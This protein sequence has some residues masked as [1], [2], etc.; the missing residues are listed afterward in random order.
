MNFLD[1]FILIPTVWFA[2]K[3]FK[4]GL[5]FEVASIIALILG[6]WAAIK[7]SNMVG[8]YFNITG[9]YVDII[10]FVITFAGVIILIFILA[11]A[12]EKAVNITVSETMNKLMGTLFGALKIVFILSILFDFINSMDTREI[13]FK[14][15]VKEASVLY[16][17]VAPVGPFLMP[18]FREAFNTIE[19]IKEPP[20]DSTQVK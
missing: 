9:P 3:G 10:S 16:P 19:N 13:V 20:A 5:V 17:Y 8:E 14:K 15:E 4:K 12:I 18:S 11:K 7:F 6:T 2:I 1:I